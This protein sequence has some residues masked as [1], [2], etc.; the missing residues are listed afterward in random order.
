MDKQ[1]REMMKIATKKE[2]S[3]CERLEDDIKKLKEDLRVQSARS[4]LNAERLR[5]KIKELGQRNL[6]LIEEVRVLAQF[7]GVD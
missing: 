3:E 5:T 6:E 1:S 7:Q 4:K 2:R